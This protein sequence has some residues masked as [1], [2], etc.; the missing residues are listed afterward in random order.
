MAPQ[1]NRESQLCCANLSRP[2]V[3]LSTGYSTSSQ[4]A[5]A[6]SRNPAGVV[7][8]GPAPRPGPL[9]PAVRLA[10]LCA[11]LGLGSFPASLGRNTFLRVP[12]ALLLILYPRSYPR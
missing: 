6:Q 2:L 1:S 12:R 7:S 9:F 4:A 5:H 3:E 11:S 10:R 8:W